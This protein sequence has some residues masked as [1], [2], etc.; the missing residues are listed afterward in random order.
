MADFCPLPTGHDVAWSAAFGAGT[1]SYQDDAADLLLPW[2]YPQAYVVGNGGVAGEN[3]TQMLARGAAAPGATRKAIA[4]ILALE[5]D[6]I[7]LRDLINDIHQGVTD[8]DAIVSR[9]GQIVTGLLANGRTHVIDECLFGY[10]PTVSGASAETVAA[11][12]AVAAAVLAKIR[13]MDSGHPRVHLV[14]PV[15]LLCGATIAFL[16]NRSYDDIHTHIEGQR[17]LAKAEAAICTRVFGASADY[18]YPTGANLIPNADLAATGSQSYGIKGTDW[19][20]FATNATRANAAIK[21][22][23]GIP[24]QTCE[25][26]PTAATAGGSIYAPFDLVGAGGDIQVTQGEV[27][28][29]EF[30]WFARSLTG[31]APINTRTMDARVRL[32]AGT[33]RNYYI[34]FISVAYD[35]HASFGEALYGRAV[36]RPITMPES[37]ANIT[38]SNLYFAFNNGPDGDLTPWEIG[39]GAPRMVLLS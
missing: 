19:G 38:A 5:P 17:L 34:P 21:V 25:F 4:D 28:G 23:D 2:Y 32:D 27:Y 14:D 22:I 16:D 15:G 39:V 11:R 36:F 26:T 12:Q 13:T 10:G 18:R 33:P 29:L 1:A 6:V 37:S 20:I 31:G 24:Y 3:T 35:N 7:L 9:H 30:R 8:T